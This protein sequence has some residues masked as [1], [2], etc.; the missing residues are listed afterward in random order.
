MPAYGE[1]GEVIC[2]LG[3]IRYSAGSSFAQGIQEVVCCAET[4]L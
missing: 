4:L 3:P 2:G 1:K